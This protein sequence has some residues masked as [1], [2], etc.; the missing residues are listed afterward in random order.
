MRHL[1]KTIEKTIEKTL[2]LAN[3]LVCILLITI[4][5]IGKGLVEVLSMASP[6]KRNSYT[7]LVF[8]LDFKDGRTTRGFVTSTENEGHSPRPEDSDRCS[9]VECD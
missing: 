9:I 5:R 1:E 4:S 2:V 8:T 6:N 7:S 3:K